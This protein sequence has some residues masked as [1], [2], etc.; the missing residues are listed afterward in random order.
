MQFRAVFELHP[1]MQRPQEMARLAPQGRD[2]NHALGLFTNKPDFDALACKGS[3]LGMQL[4]AGQ[5]D[6]R[7]SSDGCTP[8]ASFLYSYVDDGAMI[9]Q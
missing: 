4:R 7:A 2:Q 3:W 8:A 1:R 9:T 6:G 5:E